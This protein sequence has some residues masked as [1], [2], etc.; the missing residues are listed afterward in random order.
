MYSKCGSIDEARSI[1]DQTIHKNCILWTSMISGYAQS[2]RGSE[3]LKLF[4]H[5]VT[6]EGFEPDHICFTT[7]LS[8]CNHAG[9][10]DRGIQYFNKMKKDHGL[11]PKLDQYACL[12]DLYARKGHL[13]KAKELME[14]MPFTPND[15]MLSS[16]LSS[17]RIYGAVELARETAEDLFKMQPHNVAAYVTMARIYAEAGS[18]DEK[19]N[20]DGGQLGFKTAFVMIMEDTDYGNDGYGNDEN[21]KSLPHYH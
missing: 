2:G 14:E 1:F 21:T 11:V 20:C 19:I 6:E 7:I 12:V 8:A 13:R 16:F 3:G 10:L 15:I 18:W 4:D 9:F 17:C 5:F